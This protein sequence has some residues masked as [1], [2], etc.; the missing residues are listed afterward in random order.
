MD[1][2]VGLVSGMDCNLCI[3]NTRAELLSNCGR[4]LWLSE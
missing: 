1:K 2:E 3:D 4:V